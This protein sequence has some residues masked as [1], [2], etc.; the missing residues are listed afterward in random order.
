MKR[1][2]VTSLLE[3]FYS[4]SIDSDDAWKAY[5]NFLLMVSDSDKETMTY[6]YDV[7]D[8]DSDRRL[9][10]RNRMAERGFEL[11]PSQLDQYIF[12]LFLAIYNHSNG[13]CDDYT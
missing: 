9:K 5:S 3:L 8:Y 2:K 11:T 6:L 13:A 4:D 10:L 1:Q 7:I 12:L